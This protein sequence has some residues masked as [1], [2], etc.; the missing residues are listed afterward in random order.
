MSLILLAA[1]HREKKLS[2]NERQGNIVSL[3]LLAFQH[4]TKKLLANERQVTYSSVF[5]A[6]GGPF[7][8]K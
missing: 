6:I 3:V 2:A 5:N 1:L 8:K 4:S 7:R